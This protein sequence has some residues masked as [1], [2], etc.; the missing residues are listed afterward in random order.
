[1]IDPPERVLEGSAA[2]RTE[3]GFL[4]LLTIILV[5]VAIAQ[6]LLRNL[7]S[8]TL[9]WAEP[10]VRMLVLWTAFMGA[11]VAVR[12]NRHIR[13]DALLRLLS[14]DQRRYVDI[15]VH[16]FNASVC[17]LLAVIAVDFVHDEYTYD[18]RGAL[19]LPTWIFQL[20]FPLAFGVMSWRFLR[21]CWSSI[22]RT[23]LTP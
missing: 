19:D 16:L 6:I 22:A 11:L 12:E 20:I 18:M 23:S 9:L 13:I 10:V 2:E 5:V 4:V 3:D 8:I 15:V 7:F 21:Q 1:V 14:A 17:G